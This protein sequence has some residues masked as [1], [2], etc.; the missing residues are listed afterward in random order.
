M[1]TTEQFGLAI[2]VTVVALCVLLGTACGALAAVL[3]RLPFGWR[4][5]IADAGLAL[6]GLVLVLIVGLIHLSFAHWSGS[7]AG[8]ALAAAACLPVLGRAVQKLVRTGP[9]GAE[10]AGS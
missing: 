10:R 2:L 9:K 7:L 8:W 1:V 5:F 4:A 3:L 6:A